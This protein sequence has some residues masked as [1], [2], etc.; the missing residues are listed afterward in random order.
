MI[1]VFIPGYGVTARESSQEIVGADGGDDPNS[2]KCQSKV[3]SDVGLAVD[4]FAF[5]RYFHDVGEYDTE[6]GTENST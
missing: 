4:E 3:L 1:E 2:E 6:E 5:V